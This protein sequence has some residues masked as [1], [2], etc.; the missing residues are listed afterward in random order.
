M[1]KK[2]VIDPGHGGSD[3]GAQNGGYNETDLTLEFAKK[4]K[5]EL[6][7]ICSISIYPDTMELIHINPIGVKSMEFII[8]EEQIQQ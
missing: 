7:N 3:P 2:V 1:A 8:T 6:E 4:V 5:T